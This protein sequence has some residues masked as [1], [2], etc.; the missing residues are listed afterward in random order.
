MLRIAPG[1][2]ISGK[3]YQSGLPLRVRDIATERGILQEQRRRYQ[4]G[5][6]I[7][8]PLKLNDR[9]IGV[10][11]VADKR[12]RLPFSETDLELLTGIAA[13][14]SMAIERSIYYQKSEELRRISITDP[15]TSL[16]NRRYFQERLTEEIE[17]SRRHK[18]P[19]SLMIIDID[20]FKAINDTFGHPEGDEILKSLTHSIR[21]YIRVIDV[22]ARY[23]GEEFTIILPQTSKQDASVIAERICRGIERNESFQE[24]LKGRVAL[25]VSIG[26][27]SYPDDAASIDELVQ[28]ADE[29]LYLAKSKGKNQVVLYPPTN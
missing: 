19:V 22:A 10:I 5:S 18:L 9:T 25:T 1:E 28:H 6:F 26:L 15:L 21:N 29:A 7:S 14:A 4:T 23:G 13:Y 24:R 3:V 2:G 27:A 12:T 8:V 16:L 11:N 17:R 20:D